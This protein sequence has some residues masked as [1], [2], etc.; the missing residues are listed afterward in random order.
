MSIFNNNKGFFQGGGPG[1]IK[2]DIGQG[3]SNLGE[4][5][6]SGLNQFK[7]KPYAGIPGVCP[8]T[9]KPLKTAQEQQA[10]V[11]DQFMQTMGGGLQ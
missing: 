10:G 1:G 5:F 3:M 9:G 4:K 11:S 7:D 6:K 8:Y 2:F